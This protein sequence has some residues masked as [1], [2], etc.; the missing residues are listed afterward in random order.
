MEQLESRTPPWMPFLPPP[1]RVGDDGSLILLP[2]PGQDTPDTLP[3][4]V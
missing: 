4:P 3:P 1:V 2:P